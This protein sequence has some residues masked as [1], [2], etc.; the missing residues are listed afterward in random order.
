[1]AS[2]HLVLDEMRKFVQALLYFSETHADETPCQVNTTVHTIPFRVCEATKELAIRT[3][4]KQRVDRL[5]TPVLC[6]VNGAAQSMRLEPLAGWPFCSYDY[7][8]PLCM[9]ALG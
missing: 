8:K 2:L 6:F 9:L 7:S 3:K 5:T 1:M 4:Q